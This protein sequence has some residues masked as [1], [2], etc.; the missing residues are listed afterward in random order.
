MRKYYFI[1]VI[2][3][4]TSSTVNGAELRTFTLPSERQTT[5]QAPPPSQVRQVQSDSAQDELATDTN[6]AEEAKQRLD[7][8]RMEIKRLKEEQGG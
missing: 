8:L 6:K 5:M 4:S 7:E 2:A 1:A 3:L